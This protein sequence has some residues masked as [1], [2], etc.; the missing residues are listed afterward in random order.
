MSRTSSDGFGITFILYKLLNQLSWKMKI[1][2]FCAHT[3]IFSFVPCRRIN[4]G[5]PVKSLPARHSSEAHFS[6]SLMY[7]ALDLMWSKCSKAVQVSSVDSGLISAELQ[8]DVLTKSEKF[9]WS[10]SIKSWT[11][12]SGGSDCAVS[13]KC[14]LRSWHCFLDKWLEVMLTSGGV[15]G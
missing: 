1:L 11:M 14:C 9:S 7:F 15:W 12:G 4:I 8:L 10:H 3:L 2:W 6:I 5:F 13:S